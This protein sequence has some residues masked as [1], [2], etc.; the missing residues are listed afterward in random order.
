MPTVRSISVNMALFAGPV[1]VQWF[2]PSNGV[3]TPVLGS[4][5]ANSGSQVFTPSGPD[6]DGNGDWVLLFQVH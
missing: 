5:F 6:S 1:T 4:P 3:Y 2:D